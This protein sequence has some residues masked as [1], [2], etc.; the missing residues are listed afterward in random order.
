MTLQFH[1]TSFLNRDQCY[2]TL[3]RLVKEAKQEDEPESRDAAPGSSPPGPPDALG[4]CS[5]RTNLA[6][7]LP[8]VRFT[9]ELTCRLPGSHVSDEHLEP[10]LISPKPGRLSADAPIMS[11][12]LE[13]VYSETDESPASS[14]EPK[15]P[16]QS[17][18]KGSRVEPSRVCRSP[19]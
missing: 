14:A 3:M 1:F 8:A 10:V 13:E 17:P 12:R 15:P 5:S 19:F 2:T 7:A 16:P 11:P 6:L 9:H 4:V 18:Q